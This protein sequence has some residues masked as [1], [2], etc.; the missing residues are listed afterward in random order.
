MKQSY[1]LLDGETLAEIEEINPGD[2]YSYDPKFNQAVDVF[3]NEA[4]LDNTL[5]CVHGDIDP[6]H[7]RDLIK[8]VLE[9]CDTGLAALNFI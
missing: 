3:F 7:A 9:K 5:N 1:E 6:K 4:D 2:F 8:T